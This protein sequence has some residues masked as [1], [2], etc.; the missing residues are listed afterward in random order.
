MEHLLSSTFPFVVPFL[1]QQSAVNAIAMD[2]K[3]IKTTATIC[4]LV[5]GFANYSEI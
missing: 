5:Q 2:L 3:D 1:S 4:I